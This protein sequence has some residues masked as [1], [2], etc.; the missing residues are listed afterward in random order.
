MLYNNGVYICMG[1][2][3][4]AVVAVG[5]HGLTVTGGRYHYYTLSN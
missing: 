5:G 1:L 4:G 3:Q 2:L